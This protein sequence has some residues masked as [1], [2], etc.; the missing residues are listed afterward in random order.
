MIAWQILFLFVGRVN[1]AKI[2]F[3]FGLYQFELIYTTTYLSKD[4]GPN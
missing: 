1:N 4:F 2:G 3:G